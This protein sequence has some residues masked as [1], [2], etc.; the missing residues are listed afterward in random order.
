VVVSS[1]KI[2]AAERCKGY[3]LILPKIGIQRV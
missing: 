1:G 2:L 3:R